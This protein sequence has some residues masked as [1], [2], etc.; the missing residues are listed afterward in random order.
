MP[1]QESGE[2]FYVDTL[3]EAFDYHE[4]SSLIAD[5]ISVVAPNFFPGRWIRRGLGAEKWRRQSDWYIHATLGHDEN[6]GTLAAPLKTIGELGRRWGK[7]PHLSP[8]GIPY[9]SNPTTF[10]YPTIIHLLTS[11]PFDDPFFLPEGIRLNNHGRLVICGVVS[12]ERTG[13][14]SSVVSLNR[15][16]NTPVTI[17]DSTISDWS[18]SIG[19]RLR[20][21]T[22]PNAG[23]MGYVA[24]NLGGGTA[25]VSSPSVVYLNSD[26]SDDMNAAYVV[27]GPSIFSN[28]DSYS[29]DSL[30]TMYWGNQPNVS[31]GT[32]KG[33]SYDILRFE[34]LEILTVGNSHPVVGN[35]GTAV[36]IFAGCIFDASAVFSAPFLRASS[37]SYYLNCCFRKGLFAIS[38]MQVVLAS[39]L[40]LYECVMA[41]SSWFSVVD[42]D[43]TIQGAS[44]RVSAGPCRIG[45]AGIYDS[46]TDGITVGCTGAIDSFPGASVANITSHYP[47]HHVY[48][49][50]NSG[51]GIRVGAGG[52]FVYVSKIPTIVG[53]GGDFRVGN[54]NL[55]FNGVNQ[56]WSNFAA[57]APSGF[58]GSVTNMKNLATLTKS[59][60]E[61]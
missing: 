2:Y 18:T 28:G 19:K 46:P 3:D 9:A 60:I 22:G 40:S 37:H 32:E 35:A 55:S 39:G 16:T 45:V 57:V 36:T 23:S 13:T 21:T 53:N 44:L 6:P 43:F 5:D 4:N 1:P 41:T 38:H 20:V 14:F 34:N 29:L 51:V 58:G 7:T 27:V 24:K 17:T 30:P 15:A 48:G 31:A 12:S 54:A 47:A 56:T 8:P 25:R 10:Y 42:A 50:G 59:S 52:Q 11:L 61:P 49:S 26:P 33:G